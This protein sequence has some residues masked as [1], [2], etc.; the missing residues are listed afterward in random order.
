MTA[1]LAALR[2]EET[3]ERIAVDGLDDIGV[4]ALLEGLAGHEIGEEGIDLAHAVRRETGGNPFF[5]AEV[6]RHLA[7]TDAL[8]QD[9]EGRWGMTVDLASVGLPGERSGGRG[10]AGAPPG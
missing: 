9:D 1:G 7:E 6:L 10:P 3:V 8:R 5:T 4:V 2:R